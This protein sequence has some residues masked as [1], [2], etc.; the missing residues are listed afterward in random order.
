MTHFDLQDFTNPYYEYTLA[1]S[2]S[3]LADT[4]FRLMQLGLQGKGSEL[5]KSERQKSKKN[6]ENLKRIR[7]IKA[8]GGLG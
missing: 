6:I 5:R 2:N 8:C 4:F 3:R 7:R 1:Y